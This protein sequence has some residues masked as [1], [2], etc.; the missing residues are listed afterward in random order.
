MCHETS[1][2]RKSLKFWRGSLETHQRL[3][4]EAEH[5]H[6]YFLARRSLMRWHAKSIQV[7]K[8]K[9][10]QLLSEHQSR[11]GL[12][13][14]AQCFTYWRKK[15]SHHMERSQ[16]AEAVRHEKDLDLV[17]EIL[18]H[19][20]DKLDILAELKVKGMEHSRTQLLRYFP[21]PKSS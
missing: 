16:L 20:R 8:Q 7:R 14:V 17:H 1:L 5:A 3:K 12:E 18:T 6:Y 13:L 10:Q 2:Q 11:K 15:T 19:W 4:K 9:R 21:S